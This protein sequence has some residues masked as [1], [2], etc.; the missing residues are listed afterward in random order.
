V[1]VGVSLVLAFA[2]AWDNPTQISGDALQEDWEDLGFPSRPLVSG[3]ALAVTDGVPIVAVVHF[4]PL[5]GNRGKVQRLPGGAAW[6][7]IGDFPAVPGG[8]PR[9][10]IVLTS[11]GEAV[12]AFTGSDERLSETR[13][14]G[15]TWD[16]L[17]NPSGGAASSPWLALDSG[18]V[19]VVAFIDNADD[20]VYVVKSIR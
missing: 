10:A 2:L 18:D 20:Y 11:T 15:S 1:G 13:R 7:E 19:P 9:P 6:E 8:L 4:Q 5:V 14:N 16:D 3:V 12:V 17:G